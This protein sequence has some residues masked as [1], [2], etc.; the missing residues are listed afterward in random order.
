MRK[1]IFMAWLA[2]LL[3]AAPLSSAR[4][5]TCN[6]ALVGNLFYGYV[7]ISATSLAFGAYSPALA[8]PQQSTM[9]VTATCTGI[10]TPGGTLP[11]FTVAMS[12]GGGA[13]TQRLMSSGTHTLRYQ[14]YTSATF[15]TVWGDGTGSTSTVAGGNNGLTTQTITGYGLIPISQYVTPGSYSDTITV[16]VSY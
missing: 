1:L 14:L 8:T 12:A 13:F 10:L 7:S 9:T 5:Q 15:S 4:A 6:N 16:T 2:G 11:P 3:L